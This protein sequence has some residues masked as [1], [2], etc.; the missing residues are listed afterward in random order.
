[1]ETR[2]LYTR[3]EIFSQPE[4]WAQ[5]ITSLKASSFEIQDFSRYAPLE[6][7]IFTGCGSTYY[8]SCAAATLFQSLAGL[9]A[10]GVP[11][12]E[13]WLSPQSYFH[14]PD[15]TV[16]VA[17]SRSG[18]TTETIRSCE[19][20]ANE[21]QGRSITLVCDP[22][23]TLA[24]M[25][26][27]ALSLPSGMEK[28]VAQTRAFST[29]YLG[30]MGLSALWSKREDLVSQFS[31]L[32][33]IGRKLLTDY[34]PLAELYGRRLDLDRIYFL[35]SAG[36]HGLAQELSLKM[37]EMSVTHSEAFHF[38]EFRHGP[39][40]MVNHNTLVVGLVS[41]SHAEYELA[42]LDD[43]ASLGADIITIGER[44]TDVSFN[45]QLEEVNRNIL[46]LP[47]GQMLAYE[48]SIVKGYDP[49]HPQHLDQVVK[50]AG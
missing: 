21:Y 37:K 35:G 41:E 31:S 42:V 14:S 7:L 34:H 38:L 6:Q 4:A 22:H 13:L 25:G 5:A 47:F 23:S 11:A 10:R 17:I 32:P 27:L 24:N 50:L 12:S 44:N 29:L 8:L 9:L 20:F 2:G 45:S 19:A 18:E 26:T 36:R 43:I 33:V 1:M 15:A 16:L 28:S 46:Y 39:K 49:D 48:R 40:A 3:E 30:V